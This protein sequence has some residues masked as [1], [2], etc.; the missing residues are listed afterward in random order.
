MK[1]QAIMNEKVS[2]ATGLSPNQIVFAG[3]VNVNEGRLF[4]QPTPKQRKH[5]SKYMQQQLDYQEELIKLAEAQQEKTDLHHLAKGDGMEYRTLNV[6][7]YLVVRHE[8]G[9]APTKLSVRWHG[10]YRVTE[11]TKRPQGVVYTCY[12]PTTGRFYDYHASFVQSHPCTSDMEATLS[13][14]LDSNDLFVPE[15]VVTHRIDSTGK[16]LDLEIKWYGYKDPEWSSLNI[17]LKKNETIQAYL[18]QQGLT[19]FG[20]KDKLTTNDGETSPK[21]RVRFSSCVI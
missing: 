2:E 10:P 12:C 7:D 11:V 3:Q 5:M 17:D 18:E 21:K 15:R 20:L 1:V 4:P 19:Q 9:K 6:G 8:D 13:R 16:S 14:V